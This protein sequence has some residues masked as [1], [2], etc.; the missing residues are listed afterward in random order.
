MD[1][2]SVENPCTISAYRVKWSRNGEATYLSRAIWEI[3]VEKQFS[4]NRTS[5]IILT[6]SLALVAI[7]LY[8]CVRI[9]FLNRRADY[10]LPRRNYRNDDP[11]QGVTKWRASLLL[12]EKSWRKKVLRLDYPHDYET[13]PL[14]D[15]EY[16]QMK[17]DIARNQVTNELRAF[18]GTW[19]VIQYPLL[20]VLLSLSM[21]GL[22]RQDKARITFIIPLVVVILTGWRMLVLSYSSSL[23]W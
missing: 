6:V 14:T 23:G 16:K 11:A 4:M 2:D 20:T 3:S 8:T 5:R 15:N 22:F 19:G 12:D 21:I 10:K 1:E 18:V 17:A 9:E 13:R 7:A